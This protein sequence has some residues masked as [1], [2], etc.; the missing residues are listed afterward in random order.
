MRKILLAIVLVFC[1]TC[2]ASALPRMTVRQFE[3]KTDDGKAPAGAVMNMFVTELSKAGIF[4]LVEREALNYIADEQRLAMSG[5]MDMSTAPQAGKIRG[6]QYTMTGA[7]TLYYF[8]EKG[9]GMKIPIIGTYAQIN[10]AYVM[11]EIRIIDNATS[12]VIYADNK[13][14]VSE[15]RS[16][17]NTGVGSYFIGKYTKTEGGALSAATRQAVEQHVKAIKAIEW[18]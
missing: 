8:A 9:Q 12:T 13:L 11:L 2:S 1:L 17:G 4:E 18:E 6:A 15:R 10:N 7:I 3:D 16:R 14:G 5:L